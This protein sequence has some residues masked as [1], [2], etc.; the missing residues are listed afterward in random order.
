M[1]I[2]GASIKASDATI[3][4][5]NSIAHISK[6]VIAVTK[7]TALTEPYDADIAP[8][9]STP[10]FFLVIKNTYIGI[11]SDIKTPNDNVDT[12]SKLNVL[13]DI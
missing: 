7:V 4:P 12:I 6:N 13:C 9:L 10:I 11:K 1:I 2:A 3:Y 8:A 5:L